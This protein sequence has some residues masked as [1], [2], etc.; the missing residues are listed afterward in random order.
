MQAKIALLCSAF[1]AASVLSGCG[2]RD[3]EPDLIT[4]RSKS[5]SPDEFAILPTKPLILPEDLAALPEPTPGGA[6]LTDPTP[7]A[8][9]VAALGGNPEALVVGDKVAAANGALLAHAGRFGREAGIRSTLAAEDLE[10]RRKNDGRLLERIFD[11]TVYFRAYRDMSL[12][13]YDVLEYWRAKGVQTVGA[14]PEGF[15]AE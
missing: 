7:E 15:E 12:N 3:K 14:P 1:L 5:R 9:A 6:N 2:G 8:D 11:V 4:F 13:Q 10:W